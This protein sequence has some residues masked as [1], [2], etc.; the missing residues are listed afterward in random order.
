MLATV[1][2]LGLNGDCRHVVDSTL[3]NISQQQLRISFGQSRAGSADDVTLA[4]IVE[5]TSQAWPHTMERHRAITS[6]RSCLMCLSPMMC[7]FSPQRAMI[8]DA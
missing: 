7:I 2:D 6:C 4:V 8:G 5:E 1:L 3:A